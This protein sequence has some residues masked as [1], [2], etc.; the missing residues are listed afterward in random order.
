LSRNRIVFVLGM[1]LLLGPRVPCA[2]AGNLD[3]VIASEYP[4]K[5]LTLRHFYTGERLHLYGDGTLVDDAPAGTWASDGQVE[6][7]DASQNG[8]VLTIKARRIYQV[9]DPKR[10]QFVDALTLI[11]I[12]PDKQEREVEK[13]LKRRQVEIRI[14][15][16]PNPD[17]KE[18]PETLHAVF[19]APDEPMGNIAPPYY[20][21]F[22][23]KR[24]GRH[25]SQELPAGVVRLASVGSKPGDITPPH[26]TTKTDPEYSDIARQ[27]KWQG[28]A[29]LSLVVDASG[30]VQ[31]LQVT[32]PLGAGLDEKAIAAVSQWKFDPATKDGKPVAVAI[33]VEVDFKIH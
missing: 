7:R 25:N 19:L 30:S 2:F 24:E 13:S 12:N 18:I 4:D 32:Q 3:N 22:F 17:P 31:N 21:D 6:V 1:L 27:L 29:V 20:R 26:L 9:Y 16:P 10:N 14:E 15:M 11:P 33:A 28:T 5:I 8:S 23:A